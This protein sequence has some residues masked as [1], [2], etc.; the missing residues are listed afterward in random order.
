MAFD[1]T[2]ALILSLLAVGLSVFIVVLAAYR[3]Y[4]PIRNSNW[5]D[6]I[7]TCVELISKA[8]HNVSMITDLNP[9]VFE[10]P[11]M[12]SIVREAIGHGVHFNILFESE[13]SLEKSPHFSKLVK[14]SNNLIV[15]RKI[16]VKPPYHFWVADMNHIRIEMPHPA[17]EIKDVHAELRTDTLMLGVKYQKI[18]DLL[19]TK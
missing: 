15:A 1:L 18:F 19:W 14:E 11:R 17:G 10:N 9:I 6:A 3:A 2:N 8:K 7:D 12:L 16:A 13:D 4:R 5:D